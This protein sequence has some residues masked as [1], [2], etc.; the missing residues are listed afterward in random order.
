MYKYLVQRFKKLQ[1]CS[2]HVC[3]LLFLARGD[4]VVFVPDILKE[5]LQG[6]RFIG[7]SFIFAWTIATCRGVSADCGKYQELQ[8]VLIHARRDFNDLEDISN[9][10]AKT[11]DGA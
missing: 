7:E 8:T 11:H 9:R 5:I 6:T 1:T 3:Q 4:R 10:H 2:V